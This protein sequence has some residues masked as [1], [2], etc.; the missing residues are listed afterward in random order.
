MLHKIFKRKKFDILTIGGA[1]EDYALHT[2]EGVLIKNS[3]DVLRQRL[4]G[5]EYG[6]KINITKTNLS[7]GGGAANASVAASLLGL[8]SACLAAVG[9]DGRGERIIK[10]LERKKVNAS[11][12]RGVKGTDSGLSFLLV[13]NDHEHIVFSSRGANSFLKINGRDLKNCNLSKW[14]YL[15]SLSGEWE[16]ALKNVFKTKNAAIAWNPGHVQLKAGVKKIGK[17]L[18]KTGVLIVNKDEAI[19]LAVSDKKFKR[20]PE[21]F[22]NEMDNLLSILK[23]FGPKIVVITNGKFGAHAFDG[24]I[25]YFQPVEQEKKKVDTTGVGDAFGSSFISGL[26][27]YKNDI[28]KALHLGARNTA[29]AIGHEGAQN[30]LL[31]KR[32]L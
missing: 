20:K 16:D 9:H 26:I 14:L 23:S 19:E 1:T 25:N 5:F 8:K 31:T 29:S 18:K 15:T 24:K 22:L 17:Y 12:V 21:E 2:D 7:F 10:N 30:G 4:L 11:L 6:A 28:K 3:E 32:D 27:L 13:G